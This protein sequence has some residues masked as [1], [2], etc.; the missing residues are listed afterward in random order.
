MV[1]GRMWLVHRLVWTTLFGSIPEGQMI[2][3]KCRVPRCCNPAHLRIVSPGENTTENTVNR[4]IVNGRRDRCMRDLHDLTGDNAGVRPNGLRYCK[5]CVRERYREKQRA[6]GR[7][8]VPR[9]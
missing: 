7:I 8:V 9:K 4:R 3:H 2:D 6:L 1:R 5:A